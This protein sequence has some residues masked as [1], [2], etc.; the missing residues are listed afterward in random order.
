MPGEVTDLLVGG[1]SL[2]LLPGPAIGGHG[3]LV[4]AGAFAFACAVAAVILSRRFPYPDHGRILREWACEHGLHIEE[5]RRRMWLV[6]PF[7]LRST[8]QSV[9]RITITDAA[10]RQR[11]G[12]A[13]VGGFFGQGKHV[14]VIW[15]VDHRG[16]S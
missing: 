10:G 6:G 7:T 8:A 15:D 12:F 13:R 5:A 14:E 16:L 4:V 2:A 1:S 11:K 9:F 3:V